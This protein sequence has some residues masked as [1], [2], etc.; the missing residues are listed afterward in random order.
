MLDPTEAAVQGLKS[1]I[2]ST[3]RTL[4]ELEDQ[5]A[6]LETGGLRPVVSETTPSGYPGD[7]SSSSQTVPSQQ[8]K[9][10][11]L[12]LEEYKRYGRQMIIPGFGRQG[13]AASLHP[14]VARSWLTC[15][16]RPAYS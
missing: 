14:A 5:L 16:H 8:E 10:L 6:A 11:D 7:H 13:Q 3:K 12:A 4:Q 2:A 15:T 1:A 9:P